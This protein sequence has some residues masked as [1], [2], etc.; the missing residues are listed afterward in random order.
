MSGDNALQTLLIGAVVIGTGGAALGALAPAM[1]GGFFAANAGIL[2]ATGAI[3]GAGMSVLS[4]FQ[5]QDALEFERS[6]ILERNERDKVQFAVENARRESELSDILS[7]QTAVFGSRGIMLGTG[8]TKRAREISV[9]EGNRATAI[10]SLNAAT[11]ERQLL[12]KASQKR[13]EGKSAVVSGFVSAGQSLFS[14]AKSGS[15][16]TFKEKPKTKTVE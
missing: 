7:T 8:L 5:Q 11:N 6:Q 3:A 2:A 16:D 15:F 10:S 4:G 1:A 13:I 12:S 14:S 9:G